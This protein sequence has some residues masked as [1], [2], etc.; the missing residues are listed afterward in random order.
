MV[1]FR[2][3]V[4]MAGALG[5]LWV[6]SAAV[7]TVL[8]PRAETSLVNRALFATM[9]RLFYLG[10]RV[11]T[12]PSARDAVLARFA[13]TTLVML[14]VLWSAG[15]IAG[16]AAIFW[17]VDADR[18]LR[19]AV[20]L[21]GSS[22]T[23][24][25]FRSADDGI[26]V[27]LAIGEAL[28][29]L[30][31][32]ALL[33]S[34]MPTIYS[35][36]SRREAAVYRLSIQVETDFGTSPHAVLLVRWWQVG[37]VDRLNELWREWE[38]WFIHMAEAQTSFPAL[39]FFRSPQSNRHWVTTS[40]MALDT[41]AIYLS[42]LNVHQDASA[43]LMIR[44]G[45]L[46]LRQVADY[47]A[48]DYD[49]DPSPDR[50]ISITR[51]EFLEVYDELAAAG[52]PVRANREQAWR[53]YAGWRVNYDEVLL[54]LAALTHAPHAPWSSDRALSDTKMKVWRP[55]ALLQQRRNNDAQ[56]T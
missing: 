50:P 22:L 35:A 26:S 14:P 10:S 54:D 37:A 31:I 19:D 51:D 49:H 52:V 11:R 29:G 16:F 2:I 55:Y 6:L 46:S 48:I 30:G 53:D 42:T 47:F 34:F 40:G 24:L 4:G 20:A 27:L 15:L 41:A 5:V 7:R 32:V 8:V 9:R 13:P 25:G 43:A 23:T 28:I 17:A 18:T 33:I 44:T 3:A 21:S 39:N 36:F 12:E 1:I 38:D 56:S 45:Y